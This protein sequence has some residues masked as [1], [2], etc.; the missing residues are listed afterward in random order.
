MKTTLKKLPKCLYE[1]TLEDSAAEYEKCRK[2]AI[3][4]ISKEIN[5]KGFRKGAPIPETL[6]V[7]EVGEAAIADETLDTYL[8]K[9]YSKVLEDT[10][11][12]PV[13]PGSVTNIVSYNPLVIVL[14]IEVLP[15][16]ELDE[17]KIKKIKI[18]RTE[19]I[20]D[21]KE[22]D[23]A[24]AEIEK[25]FTHFHDAEGHSTDGFEA[26]NATIEVGDRVTLNTQGYDKKG[27]TAISET[28]VQ[29]FPLVI[30]SGQFIPGFEEKLVGHKLGDVVEFEITFPKDYHSDA[31]KGRKVY[32]VS[33]FARLEKPHRPEWTPEFIEELRGIKTDMAGFREIL[34]Q[35][36]LGE[37]ERRAREADEKKLLE[38]LE[39]YAT[40]ELG[41][42]LIQR[43]VESVFQEQKQTMEG[44]GYNMKMYLDHLKKDET[45]YKTEI[46]TPE[47]RRRVSAELILKKLREISN[48]EANHEEIQMEVNGIIAQYQNPEVVARLKT[49]LVPG[50]TYYEDIRVRLAYRKVVDGFFTTK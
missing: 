47:A 12:V 27:G 44:Q 22:T 16:V 33:D 2:V 1:I 9:N 34:S 30:G 28:K 25:R 8:K 21:P 49:K 3:A 15:E 19:V 7:K 20:M 48:I 24:I 26:A 37:K 13:A 6:V 32:F 31:F 35:E 23:E 41:D 46:I 18:N 11:L 38:E 50:D 5:I 29:D 42:S 45:M 40:Y 4:K 17:K 36:I 43:E 14:Q 10:K 39:K